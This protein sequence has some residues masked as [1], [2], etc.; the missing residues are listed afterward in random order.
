M[1]KS[2]HMSFAAMAQLP[3]GLCLNALLTLEAKNSFILLVGTR[4]STV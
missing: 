4:I 2:L 3:K 1:G